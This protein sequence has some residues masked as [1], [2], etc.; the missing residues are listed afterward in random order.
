MMKKYYLVV[1]LL[2]CSVLTFAQGQE[3]ENP[4]EYS[5]R[6]DAIEEVEVPGFFTKHWLG[7]EFTQRVYALR[8][9]YV[10]MPEK[11][12]TNPEPSLVTEK[13]VIY[14]AVK[15]LDRY[16]KKAMKK[17][18]MTESDVREKLSTIY[19]VGYSLRYADTA[20]L[21]KLLWT[22]KKE[23]ELEKMFLETIELY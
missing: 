5:D 1:A 15:K 13:P 23:D 4:F 2:F 6:S 9:E 7:P 21:E 12:P 17:G 22:I 8:Q 20:D 18:R 3:E 16:Y 10:Y 19:A 14:N 11:T